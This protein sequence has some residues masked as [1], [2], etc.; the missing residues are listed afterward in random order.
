MG[1]SYYI[2]FTDDFSRETK[3]A[4]LRH[5]S[6]ALTAFRQYEA[7]LVR[8]HS[9][10]CIRKLRSDRGGEYLSADFD[11]Y[12]KDQGIERQLTVHDSPQQNGVAERLNR[13]LV[14]HARAMLLARNLPKFLWAE[15]INYATWLKNRLPSRAIP[16]HTPHELIHGCKPNLAQAHEFGA[17]IYVHLQ[18]AG[19][20]EA[21]A[22]EAVYVGVDDQSKGYRI[23][24]PGKRRVSV[25]RNV[26]FVPRTVIVN[27]D[28]LDEGESEA[29]AEMPSTSDNVQ[30]VTP[31]S[32]APKT[33]PQTTQPLPVPK[34]PRTTRVRPPVGYYRALNQ[35]ERAS[36]AISELL[37]ESEMD[38]IDDEE[39]T[40]NHPEQHALAAAEPEPTLQ[41]ALN[42]PDA[43]EWQQAID[44]EIGQLEKLETW[45]IVDPPRGVN[46]IPCHFVLTTKRGPNGEK[47]KLRARLVV[48]GQHQQYGLD[49]SETFAPTSNMATIRAILTTAAQHDW[50]IHQVDIK[51]AYLN[52]TLKDNIY[53]W[54]PPGYLKPKDNGK[55][56]KLL[57]SLYGLKQAGFEWSEELE[58]FFLDAGFTRSQVDCAVYF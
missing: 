31:T 40:Y 28:I 33:P 54:P 36:T 3:I 23:Y 41:Q 35:G 26:T 8:Q 57:R 39:A 48:N 4:F 53:M 27:A 20:L 22:E 5:K 10:I 43:E 55:I 7:N 38:L 56:L 17:K 49:Y 21:R 51:S 45:K 25:E 46:I 2:S 9:G 1:S 14:E 32:Q 18:D 37:E 15:A 34:T 16:G 30:H 44:Y 58:E 24:W 42:G 52:A 6:E 13:T 47:L 19:K 12:L 50:E 11:Q 29:S